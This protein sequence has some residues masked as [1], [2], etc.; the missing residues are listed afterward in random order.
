MDILNYIVQGLFIFSMLFHLIGLPIL[1]TKFKITLDTC[2]T[3]MFTNV[4]VGVLT[5]LIIMSGGFH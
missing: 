2:G 1:V 4:L 3:L 5:L